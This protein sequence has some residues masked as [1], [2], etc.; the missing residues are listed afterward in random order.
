ML[1]DADEP[2]CYREA[3]LASD[4][5]KWEHAMQSELDSIHKNGTWDLVPLPKMFLFNPLATSRSF[6]FGF[7]RIGYILVSEEPFVGHR[8]PTSW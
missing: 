1:T 4:H 7:F 5:A 2:S 3:I 8:F 6:V